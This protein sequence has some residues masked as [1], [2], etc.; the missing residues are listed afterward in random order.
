MTRALYPPARMRGLYAIA[1]LTTLDARGLEAVAF[2][3]AVIEGG[4]RL[5]QVRAKRQE[6]G[7]VL[8]ILRA[9]RPLCIERGVVLVANDR[10]DLALLARCDAV[11]LGQTDPDPSEVRGLVEAAGLPLA[12]GVS[13][14]DEAQA[15]V[16]VRAPVDY[17]AVGPVLGTTSKENPDPVLG[18]ARARGI[19]EQIKAVREVPVVAIGGIDARTAGEL[20]GAFDAVAVISALLPGAGEPLA[21]ATDRARAIAEAL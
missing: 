9:L 16:A 21:R 4:A 3:R 1:D 13:T 12:I 20:A 5:L 14:H 17:V 11:H 19:A 6:A 18:V 8:G 10:V 2:S 15:L 7:R